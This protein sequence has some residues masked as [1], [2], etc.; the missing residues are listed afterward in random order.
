M[1][2]WKSYPTAQD[3]AT[4]CARD[5]LA[6]LTQALRQRNRASLA[7][8]GGSTPKLMF[9]AM[10]QTPFDW[11][12]VHIFFVDERCV[13]H[14][15]PESNFKLCRENLLEPATLRIANVHRMKGELTPD[16]AARDYAHE[17]DRFFDGGAPIFD[18][19]HRGMGADAHTASLFPGET[20]IHNRTGTVASVYVEKLDRHR[21]TLL[22]AVLLAARE[23]FVLAAG[24]DKADPLHTVFRGERDVEQYPSQLDTPWASWVT[25]Y[26]DHAAARR[27]QV[28]AAVRSPSR[29]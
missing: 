21:I 27:L 11:T 19:I 5:I 6:S 1:T 12:R 4:A 26:L 2:H 7:V 18:A 29:S 22:P 20:L 10:A 16:D 13:P 24:A 3:A 25:W 9:Q 23:T 28:P 17:L 14:D 8:S 15:H